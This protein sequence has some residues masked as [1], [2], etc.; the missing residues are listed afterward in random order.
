MAALPLVPVLPLA[1]NV[2][3]EPVGATR[4][5][6]L[7][8]GPNPPLDA[9]IIPGSS[10]INRKTLTGAVGSRLGTSTTWTFVVQELAKDQALIGSDTVLGMRLTAHLPNGDPITG[11]D[12]LALREEVGTLLWRGLE[13]KINGVAANPCDRADIT[14]HVIDRTFSSTDRA[15]AGGTGNGPYSFRHINADTALNAQTAGDPFKNEFIQDGAE[16]EILR[17]LTDLPFMGVNDG[18]LPGIFPVTLIAKSTPEPENLFESFTPASIVGTPFFTIQELFLETRSVKVEESISTIWEQ[19]AAANELQFDTN[20]WAT[21]QVAPTIPANSTTFQSASDLVFSTVPDVLAL[22]M[23]PDSTFAPAAPTFEKGHPLTQ[24]WNGL[25]TAKLQRGGE[26][27]RAWDNL[28]KTRTPLLRAV[29]EALETPAGARPGTLA[30]WSRA[31]LDSAVFIE[32]TTGSVVQAFRNWGEQFSHQLTPLSLQLNFQF[33]NSTAVAS[34]L[35]AVSKQRHR[36]NLSL[37][38]GQTRQVA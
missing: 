21:Q 4:T 33:V 27:V 18:L 16:F 15:A 13:L 5:A 7:L 22:A 14:Q 36:W 20:T 37:A 23:F 6:S 29:A 12:D 24:T 31:T 19:M 3:S 10:R 9:G 26:C 32:G 28:D 38:V 8:L 34:T 1:L 25:K 11:G 17:P 30:A 2:P 35:Y